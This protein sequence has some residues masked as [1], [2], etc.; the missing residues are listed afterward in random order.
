MIN[1]AKSYI[2]I[3]NKQFYIK[4]EKTSFFNLFNNLKRQKHYNF[5]LLLGGQGVKNS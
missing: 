3:R 1:T 4:L 2:P 5:A